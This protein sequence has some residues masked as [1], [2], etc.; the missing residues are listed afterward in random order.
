MT[1]KGLSPETKSS[2]GDTISF[3]NVNEN[4]SWSF[5]VGSPI[6]GG[7]GIRCT[8]SPSSGTVSVPSGSGPVTTYI[9][10]TTQYQV[11]FAVSP[12]GSGTTSPSETSWYNSG[13]IISISATPN[14]GYVFSSWSTNTSSIIITNPSSEST[15][16]TINGPGTITANFQRATVEITVTSSPEGSGF[17]K[18]DGNIIT[19]PKTFSWTPGETHTLEA[20]SPVS[21]G[22]GIQ[23]V[24]T[25]WSDGGTQIHE[26]VVP[27]YSETVTANY[28]TQYYLT[29]VSE[30]DSPKPTSGWF[31]AG[32][33]IT[34]SVTSPW[35]VDAVDTCYVCTGWT[36]TGSVPPS[37][38]ET[39]VTFTINEPSN[40]TW[41]WK[42]QYYLTVADN[43]SGFSGVSSQSGWYDKC[44]YV[45]LTAPQ[46]VDVD[47]NDGMRY[48]FNHWSVDGT[49]V[50]GNP[51]E[52]H[53]NAAHTATAHYVKQYY[54][55]VISDY[56]TPGGEG[57]YDEG[58]K[59]Y[60]I[61]DYGIEY[62]NGVP[63]W[64]VC[65]SGDASGI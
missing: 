13:T 59:A 49:P 63:Y 47:P 29:V 8:A 22:T 58:S 31:D 16:A 4:T 17:V 3:G 12:S 40:I 65:W 25:S 44:T 9:T 35:P 43:I 6:S 55:T 64:F 26:Y 28:K 11:S 21:G 1:V 30:H 36:G 34:A 24:W 53:M 37:G 38:T 2:T 54:L 61:L 62:V 20:L 10:F 60:A 7:T 46:Y 50:G 39:S 32:T 33:Q 51:I 42:T 27:G 52:V 23:Y 56:D 18:V 5:S 48:R 45:T 41:S 14:V 19:T 15:T 57:W